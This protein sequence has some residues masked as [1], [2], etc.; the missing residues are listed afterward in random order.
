MPG[1]RPSRYNGFVKTQ[2]TDLDTPTRAARTIR[3]TEMVIRKR[4]EHD[5]FTVRGNAP[6]SARLS[7]CR[8]RVTT[9]EENSH[10]DHAF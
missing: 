7:S 1:R 4:R 5:E 2:N 9:V 6:F 8:V 3:L 10:V